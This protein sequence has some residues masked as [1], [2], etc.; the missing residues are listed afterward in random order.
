MDDLTKFMGLN[1]NTLSGYLNHTLNISF[2]D[3][4]TEL[5]IADAKRMMIDDPLITMDEVA[6]RAGF[7]G[8]SYF[9]TVFKRCE[10]TTPSEWRKEQEHTTDL[11]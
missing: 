3:W 5:R 9:S 8:K 7:S 4:I 10:K 6:E 2:R 11:V 1:R